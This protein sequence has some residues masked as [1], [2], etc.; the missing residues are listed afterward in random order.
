[1]LDKSHSVLVVGSGPT[2]LTLALDLASRGVSVRIIEKRESRSELSKALVVQPRTLEALD[3][4][5]VAD[6]FVD[7]CS[8]MFKM[9]PLNDG[10]AILDLDFGAVDSKYPTPVMLRQSETERLLIEAL[11]Q[12]RV[13][14]EYS[15]ELTE[16]VVNDDA[17]LATLSS[18][19]ADRECRFD[20]V[21]GCDGSR[22]K[23]RECLGIDFVGE[24]S[25]SDFTQVDAKIDWDEKNTGVAMLLDDGAMI[26]LPL[27]GDVVR[28][29]RVRKHRLPNSPDTPELSEFQ[30]ELDMAYPKGAQLSAPEWI[31]R[32]KIHERLAE[33]YRF[34]RAFLVGDAAHVHSPAGGQGMNTGM[35]DAVNL[36]WKI[37]AALSTDDEP[38][39]DSYEQERRPV[40]ANVVKMSSVAMRTMVKSKGWVFAIAI[41][42]LPLLLS[43]PTIRRHVASKIGNLD[44]NVRN[45]K[46]IRDFRPLWVRAFARVRA[47]DRLPDLALRTG[48]GLFE[49]LRQSSGLVLTSR[50]LNDARL[51][52]PAGQSVYVRPDGYIGAIGTTPRVQS[53]ADG[54]LS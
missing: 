48:I 1:M 14:I 42:L 41:R 7:E 22:S 33:K 25:T 49:T 32:F 20:Y 19:D 6:A 12:R 45:S 8:P 21:V 10:A 44:I 15:T 40:A 34:K 3:I 38:L 35:Q 50:E 18:V 2:G 11:E 39:L 27:A 24:T 54:S 53:F 28:A 51:S 9:R 52:L 23:V 37:A 30:S 36:G 43:I 16:L 17:A 26:V 31:V 47:G 5:G 4:L 29:I 13:Y 46:I